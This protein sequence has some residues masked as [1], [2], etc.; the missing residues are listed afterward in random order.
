LTVAENVPGT[1]YL[2]HFDPP[3]R[4]ARHY[5]G[6]TGGT[7]DDRFGRHLSG[8]GSPLVRAAVQAGSTVTVARTWPGTRSDERALKS[9]RKNGAR[10][11]PT[12]RAHPECHPTDTVG[13]G[14][15]TPG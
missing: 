4:H 10:L 13:A 14:S 8:H 2:L 15:L 12:C 1:L 11:C 6:W 7:V 9:R 5:L 3:Y